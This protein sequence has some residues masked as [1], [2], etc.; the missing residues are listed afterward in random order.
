MKNS[1]ITNR[2]ISLILV[3]FLF[4]MNSCGKGEKEL[5]FNGDFG[6]KINMLG[7]DVNG[8]Q[9]GRPTL[10][11]NKGQRSTSA[12]V[13]A[14][15]VVL[16]FGE[17]LSIRATLKPYVD[18]SAVMANYNHSVTAANDRKTKAAAT[19][20]AVS[21]ELG[22][23]I[24]YRVLAYN[25]E[26][27]L[28]ASRVYQ[29]KGLDLEQ[30]DLNTGY[31]GLV[32]GE[33]YTFAVY[34]VNTTSTGDLNAAISNEGAW[35]TASLS[36]PN[37][38]DLMFYKENVKIEHG[39]NYLNVKLKHQ[40]SQVTTS[41]KVDESTPELFG[42]RIYGINQVD[43]LP[44][45]GQGSLKLSDGNITF[46]NPTTD[47]TAIGFPTI[48]AQG[49]SSLTSNTVRI[50][51]DGSNATFNIGALSINDITSSLSLTHF[52]TGANRQPFIIQPGVRYTLELEISAP[53]TRVVAGSAAL[54]IPPY[55]S[56]S[57][58]SGTFNF[59]GADYSGEV[60]IYKIDNSFNMTIN[61]QK[62][63]IGSGAANSTATQTATNE[64]QFQGFGQYA[65]PEFP[66]IEFA[67][68]ARW[69]ETG[70]DWVGSTHEIWNFNGAANSQPIIRIRIDKDGISMYGSK[71]LNGGEPFYPL[72]LINEES[73][74]TESG[75]SY[76]RGRFNPDVRWSP[77]G[78]NS[79]V[80]S[81]YV[82]GST[83]FNG[84]V[85]GTQ[86]VPCVN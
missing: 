19:R 54:V 35:T 67:D 76:I 24:A 22:D 12:E 81:Q 11:S 18:S 45:F 69:G 57:S 50:I 56:G 85:R 25:G 68:G 39:V 8:V 46:Q 2:T 17:E 33:T 14:Q 41:I 27:N 26:G 62:L 51:S 60:D 83:E 20:A 55:N 16:P 66:N 58:R 48:D 84:F 59:T 73:V 61:G 64:I 53:C 4:V 34:S 79:I 82:D 28:V 31:E 13:M 47:G 10:A 9:N 5:D 6:L 72:K 36:V 15:Q 65:R 77:D 42:T 52:G 1:I 37:D 75:T 49:V 74:T 71:N 23:N 29:Y 63:Y 43:V 38:S 7:L 21:E 44:S 32:V 86:R 70:P 78:N 3:L 80:V 40:F 30:D